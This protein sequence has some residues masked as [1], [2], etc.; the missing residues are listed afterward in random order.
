M[1][2]P[3]EKFGDKIYPV[4]IKDGDVNAA[5]EVNQAIKFIIDLFISGA[6]RKRPQ[7][8]AVVTAPKSASPSASWVGVASVSWRLSEPPHDVPHPGLYGIFERAMVGS[9][10]TVSAPSRPPL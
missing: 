3:L 8:K 5:A 1:A 7:A 4:I 9:L 6:D 2:E 10:K